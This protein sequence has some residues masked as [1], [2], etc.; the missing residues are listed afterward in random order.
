M[1]IVAYEQTFAGSPQDIIESLRGLLFDVADVPDTEAY[2]RHIQRTYK[3]AYN[4]DMVLPDTGLDGRIRAM[5]AM[6]EEA[7][8]MEVLDYA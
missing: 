2:I 7:G 3:L 5:F 6:L 8:L 4:K 1:K